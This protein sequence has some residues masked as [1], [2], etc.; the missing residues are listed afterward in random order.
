[1][2]T[3]V[4]VYSGNIVFR[5]I[6]YVGELTLLF[7]RT[8]YHIFTPPFKGYRIL[9]QAKRI[10]P[11]SFLIAALVAFFIGMIMALQM[12]YLMLEM[13]AEIY[14]P[15]VVAVSLTRELAPVLTALI[16]AGRIGAGITAE[17]GSMTVTE[18]VDALRAFAVNPVKHL[19]VPRFLGL[20]I[21]LPILTVFADIIGIMGGYVICVY[22]LF[23]S[24]TLYFSMVIEALTV[25]DIVTGL[26]KAVFFGAIIA[27]VGCHQGLNVQSGAEGVGR[28]TTKAVVVSFI[29]IIIADCLFTTLFYFILRV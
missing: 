22:K 19:V 4:A 9:S 10:G 18:Q 14:I 8:M 2:L 13:S 16:V 11:G 21:M 24:P 23:I 17:I 7:G 3:N 29:L 1:M 6:R 12:A 25:K 20:V 28:S 26:T 5:F 15:S 27:L